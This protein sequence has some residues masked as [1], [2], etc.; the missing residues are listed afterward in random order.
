MAF[1]YTKKMF[2]AP[3]LSGKEDA[4]RTYEAFY[5]NAMRRALSAITNRVL[6]G[7]MGTNGTANTGREASFK[8]G[9]QTGGT[10]GIGVSVA[11]GLLI[12][13]RQGTTATAGSFWLPVGTQSKDTFVKYGIFVGRGTSGTV[14]AGNEGA[15]STAAHIPECPEEYVCVGYMQYATTA[16]TAWNRGANV[17]TGQTGSSGTATFVDLIHMPLWD[18]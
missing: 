9:C 12:N 16:G 6:W 8:T 4:R 14:L 3:P 2:D 13:G 5:N 15:T 11:L 10:G 7:S 1:K 18:E 17:V